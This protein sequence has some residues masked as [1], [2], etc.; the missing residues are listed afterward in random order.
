MTTFFVRASGGSDAADGL[1]FAN[2]WATLQK[3]ADTML[4]G[5]LGLVASDG[6][7]NVTTPVFFDTNIG[8]FGSPIRWRGA[9]PLGEDDGS[10][11]TIDG[12]GI[13][14]NGAT[15]KSGALNT[16]SFTWFEG[17][18]WTGGVIY[19]WHITTDQIGLQFKRCRFDNAVDWGIR[20]DA[21]NPKCSF[22]DCE[23]DSN[24]DDGLA[25][26]SNSLGFA[27]MQNC[28]IHDN[29]GHGLFWGHVISL[30]NCWIY[31]NGGDGVRCIS[32]TPFLTLVNCVI[33]ENTGDGVTWAATNDLARYV[34]FNNIISNNGGWG[35]TFDG[36]GFWGIYG[37]NLFFNNTLGDVTLDGVVE[38]TL[39]DFDVLPG[40]I[41]GDPLYKN[42]TDG[43]E[44]YRVNTGSPALGAGYPQTLMESSTL[45]GYPNFPNMGSDVPVAAAGGG[46][47]IIGG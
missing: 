43:S 13:T 28:L 23:I 3:M 47:R 7:H 30:H 42:T 19:N 32:S 8:T 10:V 4:A 20:T 5:D 44:D 35:F 11:A 14:P 22:I 15:F 1:S 38:A 26:T 24:G 36:N 2:A 6:V 45:G 18:R 17:L 31:K 12:S 21:N 40:S 16:M 34:M 41:T 25:Q 39:A 33:D 37:S 29:V 46:A 9:G 27:Y